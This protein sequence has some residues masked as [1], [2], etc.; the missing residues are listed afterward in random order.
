M[1]DDLEHNNKWMSHALKLAEL[2]EQQG[3]IPVGAVLVKNDQIIGEGWN[4]SITLNDPTAHAEVMAIRDAGNKVDNYRLVG[5]TL[6]VTLEP[7]SMC[8]G[9]LVHARIKRVVYGA[10]DAKTG[11]AGSVMNI[12]NHP[13]LN[14]QVDVISGVL[15][16]DCADKI[17]AFFKRRRAQIKLDK[18]AKQAALKHCGST[19]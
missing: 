5:S 11:A 3:E 12:L 2:A 9:M 15:A 6:Y 19:E 18:K 13:S 10:S 17:S 8:A 14:H 7:C 16:D 1:T 4:Q